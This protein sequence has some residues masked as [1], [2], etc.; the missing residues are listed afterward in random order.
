M[1]PT[2]LL[3]ADHRKVEDLFERISD[4]DE[5][6]R[7]P[8]IDELAT[9]L[10]AHMQLEEEV[11]YP[12]MEPVTGAESVQEG[13]TEHELARKALREMLALAPAQPGFEAALDAVKAGV[14]HHVEDEEGEVFPKLRKEGGGVLDA[15]RPRV[16][17]MRA[18]LGLPADASALA[19][20][21]TKAELVQDAKSAGVEGYSSMTKEQLAEAILANA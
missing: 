18:Q 1:D 6:A 12:A 17:A 7:Q 13:V 8:L 15:V 19:E 16:L 9:S 3:E 14:S 21:S 11:L 4:A 10:R 20:S 5:S 2:K